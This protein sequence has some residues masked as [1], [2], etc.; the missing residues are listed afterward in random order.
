M[1]EEEKKS[2]RGK[3][4][5]KIVGGIVM[6]AIAPI[7]SAVGF[8]TAI[9]GA[10][11]GT[12]GG[13]GAKLISMAYSDPDKKAL[14]Q[15]RGQRARSV[16][17]KAFLG[18]LILSFP[19][20][21]GS[22]AILEGGAQAIANDDSYGMWP[23]LKGI[24]R[25]TSGGH[26]Q[27]GDPVNDLAPVMASP[28]HHDDQPHQAQN[29]SHQ[30]QIQPAVSVSTEYIA[31]A[32]NFEEATN[33]YQEEVR[34]KPEAQKYKMVGDL[35]S[36][37]NGCY[38][39]TYIHPSYAGDPT[40]CPEEFKV[41]QTFNDKMELM[42]VKIGQKA[43]CTVPPIKQGNEFKLLKHEN[44]QVVDCR[45]AAQNAQAMRN[46]GLETTSHA[47]PAP[48]KAPQTQGLAH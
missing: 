20:V 41:K 39:A 11:T 30:Q 23:A 37:P 10:A 24:A 48:S 14:W 42:G 31:R 18:G 2:A 8:G 1:P 40:N 33:R 26:S 28:P 3:A 19:L 25:F 47:G 34:K 45:A 6:M 21:A 35:V 15:E 7:T 32:A 12:L 4:G 36:L 43:E 27:P 17:T 13:G 5:A 44:G 22:L 9:L 46:A 16:G 29:A 38:E